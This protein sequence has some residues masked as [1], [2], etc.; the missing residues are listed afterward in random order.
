MFGT[1]GFRWTT[2]PAPEIERVISAPSSVVSDSR[3]RIVRITDPL[4]ENMASSGL[5]PADGEP[6]GCGWGAHL[7]AGGVAS[8]AGVPFSDGADLPRRLTDSGT[9]A[10]LNP[11]TDA[12]AFIA[13]AP[14]TF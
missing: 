5:R 12:V 8:A 3:S 2:T 7:P 14:D 4:G 13:A 9:S 11:S 6:A 1:A 10:G